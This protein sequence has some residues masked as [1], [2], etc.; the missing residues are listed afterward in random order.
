MASFR[1]VSSET[2]RLLKKKGCACVFV[3]ESAMLIAM[4]LQLKLPNVC[5]A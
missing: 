1:F 5:Q 4:L 2:N 3:L